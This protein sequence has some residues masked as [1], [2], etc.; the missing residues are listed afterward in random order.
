MWAV[1]SPFPSKREGTRWFPL[2]HF[3]LI[4]LKIK[5]DLMRPVLCYRFFKT[6]QSFDQIIS[7]TIH[8]KSVI[9]IFHL[10][11]SNIFDL[12]IYLF[13]FF[14]LTAF[15][16]LV[17]ILTYVLMDN[18][19]SLFINISLVLSFTNISIYTAYSYPWYYLLLILQVQIITHIT[20]II[21]YLNLKCNWLHISEVLSITHT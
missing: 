10:L 12:I 5:H 11:L 17:L 20:G 2:M 18:F 21:C 16:V 14:P 3:D 1:L 9:P 15:F 13:I 19:L 7:S 6:S 8:K 4:F